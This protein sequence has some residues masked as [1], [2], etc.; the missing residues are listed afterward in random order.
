[1]QRLSKRLSLAALV[2]AAI[3]LASCANTSKLESKIDSFYSKKEVKES[4]KEGTK[5]Y[6]IFTNG[7]E[8]E[9]INKKPNSK[10]IAI[11][12]LKD[13]NNLIIRNTL[14]LDS[15]EGTVYELD[16]NGTKRLRFKFNNIQVYTTFLTEGDEMSIHYRSGGIE[17]DL[18]S[19][20]IPDALKKLSE[21]EKDLHVAELISY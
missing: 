18:A 4:N 9:V 21:I 14:K 8:V 12:V 15:A 3:S 19:V 20:F 7:I 6:Y 10:P 13:P 1:M 5:T 17:G 2:L 11:K 16:E